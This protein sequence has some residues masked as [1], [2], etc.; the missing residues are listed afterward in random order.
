MATKL[1]CKKSDVE[2]VVWKD[3]VS[4]WTR[5]YVD[6]AHRELQSLLKSS[7]KILNLIKS[8]LQE[9]KA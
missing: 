4:E 2:F 1:P 7:R 3:A 6:E 5:G 8:E 9:L